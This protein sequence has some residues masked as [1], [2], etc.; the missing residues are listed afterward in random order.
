MN[1]CG[2]GPDGQM[3]FLCDFCG[4]VIG[5]SHEDITVIDRRNMHAKCA[6]RYAEKHMNKTPWERLDCEVCGEEIP[7]DEI[8]WVEKP[9]TYFAPTH[10]DCELHTCEGM[11]EPKLKN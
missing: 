11:I 5:E 10:P 2:E 1:Q 7:N 3:G 9:G 8:D 6:K 4:E